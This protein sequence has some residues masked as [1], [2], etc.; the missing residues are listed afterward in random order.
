M[1]TWRGRRPRLP[2]EPWLTSTA[3]PL[4]EGTY[5]ADEPAA[6][7]DGD[8][9]LLVRDPERRLVDLPARRVGEQVG[10]AEAHRDHDERD[11]GAGEPAGAVGGAPAE[12]GPP[13]RAPRRRDGGEAGRDEQEP[14]DDVA[15]AGDVA[16]VAAR[17]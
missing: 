11:G 13:G 6:V 16:P 2:P 10:R 9:D 15:D 5:H 4:R 8:P 1:R 7:V 14:A 12:P 17:S 3:A